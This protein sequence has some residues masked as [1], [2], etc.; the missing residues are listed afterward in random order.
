M[1]NEANSH[2]A[3][4]RPKTAPFAQGNAGPG[5]LILPIGVTPMRLFQFKNSCFSQC[6][7]VVGLLGAGCSGADLGS[8]TNTGQGGSS[9]VTTATGGSAGVGDTSVATTGG[10][11]AGSSSKSGTGGA[12]ST[13]A[14]SWS[15]L[16][17]N[18]FG[19]NTPGNCSSCHGAG[20]AP[21]FNS[22]STLCSALKSAGY[23]KNSSGTLQNLLTWFGGSGTMPQGGGA[24]PTKAVSDITAWQTAG[25]VCP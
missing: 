9:L 23:I 11:W 7:L 8:T 15:Q 20:T 13:S 6:A 18:Y 24:V 19:P 22:A 2:H 21:S 3:A 10:S 17:S 25:A 5:T 14:P 4:G 16:Y 1:G 12:A